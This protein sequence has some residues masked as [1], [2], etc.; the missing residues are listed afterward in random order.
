MIRRTT[1]LAV[2]AVVAALVAT[3][4]AE[5]PKEA[6]QEAP[7]NAAFEQ[8]KKLAGKWTGKGECMGT[9]MDVA[10]TY[11]VTSAGSAVMETVFAGTDHDMVTMYTLDGDKLILT[12][13]CALG[14]QPRMKAEKSDDPKKLV[15]KFLDG[16]NLDAAKDMHM[17]EGAI[18]WVDDNH[19]KSEWTAYVKGKP[20]GT[21]KIDL[22]RQKG[23]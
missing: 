11:K 18:E 1:L 14:N 22:T 17:H 20:A 9:T 12:H 13:Y 21:A 7:K 23:D 10:V 5:A 2:F 3:G 4:Y 15:F 8:L 6:K 19:I 16:T